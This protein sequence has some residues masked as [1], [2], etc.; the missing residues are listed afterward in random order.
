MAHRF[1]SFA[2]AGILGTLILVTT[3]NLSLADSPHHPRSI[4]GRLH[5][6]QHRIYQGIRQD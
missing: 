2:F 3:P 5:H 1:T 4:H 6:Q